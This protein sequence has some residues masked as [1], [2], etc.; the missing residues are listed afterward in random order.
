MGRWFYWTETKPWSL[1]RI[2]FWNNEKGG[3]LN[4]KAISGIYY[5]VS[6]PMLRKVA[7]RFDVIY[8]EGLTGFKMDCQND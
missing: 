5:I 2:F 7:E 1:N 3:K 6:T 8:M 4:G